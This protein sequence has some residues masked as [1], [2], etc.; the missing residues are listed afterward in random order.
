M[1]AIINALMTPAHPEVR[2]LR[3]YG[4]EAQPLT[5]QLAQYFA[6]PGGMLVSSVTAQNK[7]ER[8]G[9]LAGDVILKIGGQDVTDLTSVI[10]A[11]D[12]QPTDTVEI[13]V[14][15]QREQIKLTFPR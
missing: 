7:A 12:N 1:K 2:L 6:A 10:Q 3:F 14:L 11:L 15:R 13:L 8:A 9:M 5:A 4:F